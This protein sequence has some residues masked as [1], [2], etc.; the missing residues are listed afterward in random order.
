MNKKL[1]DSDSPQLAAPE[2]SGHPYCQR[3]QFVAGAMCGI[4]RSFRVSAAESRA[5]SAEAQ[6]AVVRAELKE[7]KDYWGAAPEPS[8]D[9]LCWRMR[10]LSAEA[11]LAAVRAVTEDASDVDCVSRYWRVHALLT[12]PTPGAGEGEPR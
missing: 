9:H 5:E 6:L 2:P 8:A 11:L 10:A 4:C 1:M 7:A 12:R 3:C